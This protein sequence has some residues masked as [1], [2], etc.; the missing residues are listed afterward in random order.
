MPTGAQFDTY[1]LQLKTLKEG[2]NEESLTK[3][4]SELSIKPSKVHLASFDREVS[5]QIC[6]PDYQSL[7][8]AAAS[9]DKSQNGD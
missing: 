7:C 6:F 5:A 9:I 4:L 2:T 3:A 8:N 1:R